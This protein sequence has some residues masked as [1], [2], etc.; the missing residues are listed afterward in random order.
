MFRSGFVA[1]VGMPNSGKSTLLNALVGEKIAIVSPKPQTTRRR[2]QGIV[3]TKDAQL[4]LCDAPGVL[5]GASSELNQFLIEEYRDVLSESDVALAILPG[6]EKSLHKQERIL[7][8][9]AHSRKPFLVVITK[10]DLLKPEERAQWAEELAKSPYLAAMKENDQP[11]LFTS[12]LTQ[13]KYTREFVLEATAKLLPTSPALYDSELFTT[14]TV[15]DMASEIIREKCFLN[16]HQEVPFGLAI[17]INTFDE[18]KNITRIE[19]DI[20]VERESHKKIVIGEKASQ[21]KRI[22]TEARKELEATLGTKVFLGLHVIC[23]PR[24]MQDK[25][26]LKE[27]GYVKRD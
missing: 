14:E 16:L 10:A 6:D 21:L 22:G 8:L 11:I 1:L 17:K 13:V 9:V 26:L 25:S 12:A 24:W 23:K 3:T 2:I 5:E 15:R 19:A 27:L 7:E 20:L 4:I 18:Q